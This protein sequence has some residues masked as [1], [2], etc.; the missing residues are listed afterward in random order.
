MHVSETH[1]NLK[2]L[3]PVNKRTTAK[4]STVHKVELLQIFASLV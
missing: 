1:Y 2:L 4:R 3:V